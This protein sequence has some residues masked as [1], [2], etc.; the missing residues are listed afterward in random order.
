[1][2]KIG[3][4]AVLFMALCMMGGCLKDVPLTDR[5]MDIVAEYAARALLGTIPPNTISDYEPLLPEEVVA[6][7][8]TP[9]PTPVPEVTPEPTNGAARPTGGTPQLTPTPV[10]E[11]SEATNE[12]LT[13]VIGADGFAF[14]YAEGSYQLMPSVEEGDYFS[15]D[16]KKGRQYL[17]VSFTATNTTDESIALYT[18]EKQLR[19]EVDINLGTVSR[20]S[21]SM[22]KNDLQYMNGSETVPAGGSLETV[23]VF[24]ISALEEIN[25][26]HIR[27]TNQKDE[28]V[29][30]KL[31]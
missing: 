1:M 14:S 18:M 31:K 30:I 11:N 5:E 7:T 3:Y 22:L 8:P 10:P 17:I 26:A 23:L 9:T 13:E 12:Q 15:L 4:V 21:L 6:P 24:E 16:P 27:I 28:V 19:C 20:A 29:I 2:K 25:T